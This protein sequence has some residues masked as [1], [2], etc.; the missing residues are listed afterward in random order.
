MTT[1]VRAPVALWS[2]LDEV[3]TRWGPCAVTIGVFDGLHR[4]HARLVERTVSLARAHDVPAV[5]VTFDPHPARVVGPPRDTATL[6]TPRRRAELAGPLGVDA[7]LVLPFTRELARSEPSDFVRRVLVDRLGACAVVVGADFRFG[8]QG[9]GD[10]DLLHRLGQQFGFVTEGIDVVR[11]DEQR[12]SSTHVRT[13]LAGGDVAAAAEALGRP[14]RVEARLTGRLLEV[15]PGTAIPRPGRYRGILRI[16]PHAHVVDVLVDRSASLVVDGPPPAPDD[17]RT[18][19]LDFLES[20][21][22]PAPAPGAA[23]VETHG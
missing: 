23:L 18:A 7:V 3:P 4:G 17:H 16:G 11:L 12:C 21:D 20:A 10:V 1:A 9:I 8:A 19:V 2:G 13:C 15:A 6:S 22:C 5:M 14:H